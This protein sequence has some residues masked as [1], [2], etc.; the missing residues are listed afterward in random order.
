MALISLN[1][2]V[3]KSNVLIFSIA[4]LIWFILLDSCAECE[5]AKASLSSLLSVM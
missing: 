1:K 2:S 5:R 4:L 3:V